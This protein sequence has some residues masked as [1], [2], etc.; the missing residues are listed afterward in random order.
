MKNS[1]L[2]TTLLVCSSFGSMA[3]AD[4]VELKKSCVKDN[5]LVASE[6][7]TTLLQI[8][9]QVCDKKNKDNKNGYLAQAAQQFQKIGKNYKALQLVNQL[10]ANNVQHSTLTDVKFLAG[11][12]IANEAL[13][14]IRGTEVRYLTDETYAPAIALNDAVKKAKPL[15]VIEPKLEEPPKRAEVRSTRT[16]QGATT[17]RRNTTAKRTRQTQRT[18]TPTR[19]SA[20]AAKPATQ[21]QRTNPFGPL[22]QK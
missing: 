16:T 12:G 13:T 18:V 9:A 5:P 22:S 10:Q 3:Y 21:P 17:P 19:T 14:Q 6:T 11:I 8:Y 15:T 20:P 1:I 4:E 2:F 7:D